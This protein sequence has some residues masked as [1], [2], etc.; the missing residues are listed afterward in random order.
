M[1][2][3]YN[4]ASHS[5]IYLKHEK[6]CLLGLK[7]IIELRKSKKRLKRNQKMQPQISSKYE[8]KQQII[9]FKTSSTT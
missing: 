4:I 1:A 3:H 9:K 2:L 5:F 8:N 6:F 7:S